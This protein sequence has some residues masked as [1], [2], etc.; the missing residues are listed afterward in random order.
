MHHHRMPYGDNSPSE[1]SPLNPS[2]FNGSLK[3]FTG[4]KIIGK[5]TYGKVYR[6]LRTADNK[7]YDFVTNS[8][9]LAPIFLTLVFDQVCHKRTQFRLDDSKR[10]ARCIERGQGVGFLGFQCEHDTVRPHFDA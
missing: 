10:K 2:S 4:L 1:Q 8:K 9:L 6:A 5:G 3:D 7:E